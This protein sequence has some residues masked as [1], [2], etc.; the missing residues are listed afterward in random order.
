M[1]TIYDAYG[2]PRFSTPINKD[3]KRVYKLMGDDYITLKLSVSEPIGFVPGDYCDIYDSAD[4]FSRY[5]LASPCYPE[6]NKSTG[7]YDYELRL[8]AQYCKWRNKILRYSPRSGATECSFSLSSTPEVHL[9]RIVENVNGLADEAPEYYAGYHYNGDRSIL[10][11]GVVE[12][13]VDRSAKTISYDGINIIDALSAIA[14]AYECEWWLERNVIRLGKCEIGDSN[15]DLEIGVNVAV[16]TRSDSSENYVTR[17]LP[18]GSERNVS[19]RY[20]KELIFDVKEVRNGGNRISDTSRPL[21]ASM[22]E[23]DLKSTSLSEDF[24][25]NVADGTTAQIPPHPGGGVKFHS[26]TLTKPASK[27]RWHLFLD[28]FRPSVKLTGAGTGMVGQLQIEITLSKLGPSGKPYDSRVFA[29]VATAIGRDEF[30]FTH[31]GKDP[32]TGFD[33]GT[34][35]VTLD[36]DVVDYNIAIDFYLLGECKTALTAE[37]AASTLPLR[38]VND[39]SEIKH[40]GIVLEQI[41]SEGNVMNTF[42]RVTL[43]PDYA[44]QFPDMNWLE[45]PVGRIMHVGDRFRLPTIIESKV[46]SSFFTPKYAAY[47]GNGNYTVNGTVKNRLMLP[48]GM[49]SY[50][51]VRPG[52]TPAEAAEDIV[53]FEDIYPKKICMVTDVTTVERSNEE[54]NDDNTKT[55]QKFL[56]YAIKDDF[57]NRENPFKEYFKVP[58]EKIKINFLDGKRYTKD[59]DIPEGKRIGDLIYEDSGKLNGL[60]FEVEDCVP[61]TDGTM[62]W[63]VIRDSDSY[64][65]NELIHPSVGDTFV[66]TGLDVSAINESFVLDAEKEL[67]KAAQKYV[68][69]LNTDPSTYDCTMMPDVMADGL[70][71]CLGQRVNLINEAFIPTTIDGSGRRI[72][73]ISRVI[74][75][76]YNLDYPYDNPVYTI[77]EKASYSRFGA[78]ED[79]IDALK[80]AVASTSSVVSEGLQ[81]ERLIGSQDSI[82]PNDRNAFS[83]LRVVKDFCARAVNEA[84]SGVWSF[85]SGLRVGNFSKGERGAA[86]ASDGSA[87]FASVTAREC[88]QVGNEFHPNVCGSRI[89]EDETGAMHFETDYISVRR[90]MQVKEMEIQEQTHVGGLQLISP[91]AMR[92]WRV[93]PIKAVDGS[94]VIAY[95]CFFKGEDG[96]GAVVYNQFAVGDLARCETFNLATQFDGRRGNRFYWRKVIDCGVTNPM[97]PD[98]QQSVGV[99]GFI[100]LSNLPDEKAPMSDAPASGDRIVAVGNCDPD[101]KSRS[102]LIVIGSYGEGSPYIH[103]YKGIDTFSLSRANLKTSIAPDNNIFTGKFVLESS[104]GDKDI[105]QYIEESGKLFRIEPDRAQVSLP[106]DESFPQPAPLTCKVMLTVGQKERI[107]V[108]L[109][110]TAFTLGEHPLFL[111][112][113]LYTNPPLLKLAFALGKHPLFINGSLWGLKRI[114]SRIPG[115]LELRYTAHYSDDRIASEQTYYGGISISPAMIRIDFRLYRSG[116]VIDIV[117]VPMIADRQEVKQRF[118]VGEGKLTSLIEGVGESGEKIRSEITQTID[119]IKM[120]VGK[121]GI[122]I[123]K[124]SITL[125][126][127]K[128]NF[129]GANNG[130]TSTFIDEN[131]YIDSKHI[132][133]DRLVAGIPDGQRIEIDPERK[134][135]SIYDGGGQVCSSF[136]GQSFENGGLEIFDSYGEDK[137]VDMYDVGKGKLELPSALYENRRE[138]RSYYTAS[139]AAQSSHILTLNESGVISCKAQ[140]S[141][142]LQSTSDSDIAL[143]PQLQSEASLQMYLEK[144]M[145]DGTFAAVERTLLNSV[146]ASAVLPP[147]DDV[148]TQSDVKHMAQNNTFRVKGGGI[149]R[150]VIEVNLY[151]TGS[152]ALATASWDNVA[153]SWHH[154]VYTSNFFANGLCIG[155][156]NDSYLL[157]HRKGSEM[158]MEMRAGEYGFRMTKAGIAFKRPDLGEWRNFQPLIFRGTI[159]RRLAFQT[160]TLETDYSFD[161]QTPIMNI[162]P[163]DESIALDYIDLSIPKDWI[164]VTN[165][166][167]DVKPVERNIQL[168]TCLIPGSGTSMGRPDKIRI[169]KGSDASD[170]D[171][172]ITITT[173][174]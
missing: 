164:S 9:A 47:D 83:S 88:I 138:T 60:A 43:N 95:K 27:G 76:E 116:K 45:L 68:E 39:T 109:L 11:E 93:A 121:T 171:I 151:I 57:F 5:E 21:L 150:I 173:P 172:L 54:Q 123:D 114:D 166:L 146:V 51:D 106:M 71:L 80:F 103:Q 97:H 147:E 19:A 122:D 102:N 107:E 127:G 42:E 48:E 136:N 165:M 149:Y 24:S 104:S 133:V 41:D 156:A 129:K 18:Y 132:R 154:E 170:F 115:D 3:S 66:L 55:K 13:S 1:V 139:W 31:F 40:R 162:E 118:E 119:D 160:L 105:D 81:G 167:I 6:V 72:G 117:S 58:N 17:I 16:M 65:P 73:R 23:P 84:V 101:K 34:P 159:K 63:V 141:K 29:S 75:F 112:R 128:V 157:V 82:A 169:Y 26:E 67:L 126:A 52:L 89:W 100:T 110:K 96:E 120:A 111:N 86:I 134:D 90:K 25:L 144:D 78:I 113:T 163:W 158:K 168:S 36:K 15:I 142:T 135:I 131:G 14:E 33:Y 12:S 46:K 155:A 35:F 7:A 70:Q 20:R 152:G 137:A 108:P 148:E 174:Y 77:G 87:E 53:V 130:E 28:D 61:A 92:C 140:V 30:T 94:E 143:R 32:A 91:A 124:E 69:K 59:D 62:T 99:E 38:L 85:F 64:L 8:E 44:Q 49:P 10:W 37:I 2:K 56:A 74:G 98:Y 153:A 22:F 161:G 79:K 50:V 145:G 125:T 4:R